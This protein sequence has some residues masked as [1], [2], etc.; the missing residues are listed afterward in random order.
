MYHTLLLPDVR[1][2]LRENDAHGLAEFCEALHPAVVASVMGELSNEEIWGVLTHCSLHR[3]VEIIE[4]LE[5]PRQA[6]LV[7]SLDRER[8]SNLLQVMAPDDCV[9]LLEQ[10]EH[11][12][13]ERILPLF[14]QAQRR[15]IRRL[16]SYPEGSAGSIMT[17]E[18][19]SLREGTTV[20]D[21]L[22]QLRLQAP[23]R[24]TIYYVY[25]VDAE[26]KLRGFVSLRRLILEKTTTPIADIMDRD[27]I[28]V[29]VD[30]DQE[31]VAQELAKYDFL[32]IPVVDRQNQL[33]GIIT[34]DDIL[35]VV[36][37][38]ATE[39]AHLMGGVGPG[40]EH[41]LEASFVSIWWRRAGWLSC[42]FVAE[43]FTF[44][45]LAY[46]EHAIAAVLALSLFLPLCIS[47]GGNSGSQAATLITRA[48]ALGQVSP[49][50]WW[51]VLRHE[52]MMGV[53]LGLTLGAIGFLRASLTPAKVLGSADRWELAL[54][55]SQSVA[56]ICLWGTLVGAMLPLI[57]RKLGFDPAL[58]SSPFVATF[59]DVTGIIIYFN[60]ASLYVL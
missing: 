59:V 46:F 11:D 44:T 36:Q 55:I 10:M 30:E 29:R 12:Q 47:T 33:V 38:E 45:A 14:A 6:E 18:Y 9:D 24:E 50:D 42:L 49:G 53:A 28:S 26:R 40:V 25:V 15:D 54:V 27:V 1:E 51:R 4:F 23:N 34:H 22:N 2:M 52:L 13:V 5:L 8:L 58:A 57:F 60:I 48:M 32:A 16:L 21:A 37:E 43:L 41:Y 39:D 56:A 31:R 17:T 7:A 19:A 3:Q 35:D 20:G